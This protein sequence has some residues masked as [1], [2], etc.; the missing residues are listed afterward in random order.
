MPWAVI[1][2]VNRNTTALEQLPFPWEGVAA[3]RGRGKKR[4]AD[5]PSLKNSGRRPSIYL[6]ETQKTQCRYGFEKKYYFR[7]LKLRPSIEYE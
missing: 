4:L 3:G 6:F 5:R 2:I 7:A 1:T